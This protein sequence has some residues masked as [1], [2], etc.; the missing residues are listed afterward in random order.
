MRIAVS[1]ANALYDEPISI[2]L[3]GFPAL[4]PVVVR[5]S[6]D[7]DLGHRWSSDAEFITDAKGAV[8]LALATPV[9]GSYR[10]ADGMGLLWSMALDSAIK[11]RTPFTKT[12]A[13]PVTV[14]LNAEMEGEVVASL[15]LSRRLVADGVVRSDVTD[16]GLVATMFHHEDGARPG[17]ILVGG[18]G[19]G[20]AIDHPAIL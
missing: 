2:R 12:T 9:A 13:E 4:K 14:K 20:L 6:A 19:G 10:V 5:G 1:K 15:E 3:E 17:V 16:D 11:E 18:S 8:D 7:D